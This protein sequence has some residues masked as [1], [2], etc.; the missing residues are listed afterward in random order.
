MDSLNNEFIGKCCKLNRDIYV[1]SDDD[2]IP[3]N[4]NVI[5]LEIKYN[6]F[7]NY[8]RIKLLHQGKIFYFVTRFKLNYWLQLLNEK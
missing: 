2:R 8:N 1:N 3:K 6:P 7:E 4:S 5:V